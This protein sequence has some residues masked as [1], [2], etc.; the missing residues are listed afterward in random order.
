MT[1]VPRSRNSGRGLR[2]AAVPRP[3]RGAGPLRLLAGLG[4]LALP[5]CAACVGPTGKGGSAERNPARLSRFVF[6]TLPDGRDVTAAT[7]RNGNGLEI[8]VIAYGAILRSVRVPDR[9]G[10]LGDV[11]LGFDDLAGYLGDSPYFGAV[12]GRY[13]NRIAGG[14]FELGGVRHE[15]ARNDG[16]NH[17]HGGNRGF[18]KVLWTLETRAGED[19]ASAHLGYESAAGEE[20][21][22]GRLTVSVT[23]TLTDNDELVMDYRAVTD[24]PTPVNLS[25]HSYFDLSAGASSDILGHELL[26][27]ADSLT[28]V[29]ETLIPTGEIVPVAGT[30]FDFTSPLTIGAR[31]D[32]PHPQLVRGGG[33]DHNLVLRE[34]PGRPE[35]GGSG[36]G[37]GTA[38]LA[39]AARV[40]EPASGRVL[41]I[42]TSEP[43]I[44]FYS[45]NFLDGSIVGKGGR[46][47]GHRSGLCLETQHYPD[48]PNQPGFPDTILR[49]GDEYRSRT[50]WRF[51]VSPGAGSP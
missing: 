50:V 42:F 21:Y 49:P 7:L 26:L 15:L 9:A 41:D 37:A 13:A 43:G 19:R 18:D 3:S 12:V 5:L 30:P 11:T 28:P 25:Q 34:Q 23:Y 4:T 2:S 46:A 45:G 48:S 17:L 16:P 1:L 10:S 33:Y 32:E 47:Y 6:G 14:R 39:H 38:G 51:S 36:A 27:H 24:A 22:P 31:I 29:D 40:R 20:G 8:E 35:A 44:Q